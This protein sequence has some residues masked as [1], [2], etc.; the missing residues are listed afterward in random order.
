MPRQSPPRQR[1]DPR[2]QDWDA[3]ANR[4]YEAQDAFGR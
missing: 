2:E 1:R 3:K 4:Q